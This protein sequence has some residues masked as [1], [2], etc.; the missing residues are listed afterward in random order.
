MRLILLVVF[1]P[2]R[3]GEHIHVK[4]R[5]GL[6]VDHETEGNFGVSHLL[7]H[8][9][10]RSE[11]LKDEMSFS[12]LIKEHETS[13]FATVRRREEDMGDPSPPPDTLPWV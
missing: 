9:L 1:V 7:E 6:G 11:V 4:L 2:D 8:M 10:F 13:F 12:E 5:V 3:F